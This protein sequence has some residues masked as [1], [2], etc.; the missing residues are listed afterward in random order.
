MKLM[1]FCL[2]AFLPY[3]ATCQVTDIS[4]TAIH[5]V[6]S[7]MGSLSISVSNYALP[8]SL[9][10]N[11][12]IGYLFT[13]TMLFNSY[14]V[15]NL[16]FGEYCIQVENQS[17]CTATLCIII[18]KCDYYNGL[19][20]IR[21]LNCVEKATS[22]DEVVYAKG[23]FDDIGY[24]YEIIANKKITD[25]FL[26]IIIRK[27]DTLTN[28]IKKNG[29]TEY[30]IPHQNEIDVTGYEYVYKFYNVSDVIWVYHRNE[31]LLE[32]TQEKLTNGELTLT[33]FPNPV[34][35]KL[36]LQVTGIFVADHCH[37]SIDNLSGI[38][39]LDKIFLSADT[40]LR[41]Q[42]SI[43]NLPTGLYILKF[44]NGGRHLF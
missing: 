13:T 28:T 32:R 25:S 35:D 43:E 41:D 29:Y 19:D 31:S 9:I 6:N 39:V 33:V 20:G 23:N 16:V 15:S 5:G 38:R 3:M 30:D 12:P 10:I 4:I 40:L 26:D 21:Y 11:G 2:F 7:N 37:I 1:I 27:I 14:T 18:K 8:F 36:L 34:S 44:S 42:I 17:Q 22:D 24:N